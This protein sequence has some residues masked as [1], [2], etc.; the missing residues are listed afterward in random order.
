MPSTTTA[1]A[2]WRQRPAATLAGLGLLSGVISAIYG[3][4]LEVAWLRPVAQIFFLDVGPTPIGL[5]FAAAI[6]IGLWAC[7]AN[8]WTVPVALV[9]AMYAWSAA[10]QVAFR[11]QRNSGDDLHLIGASLGAGAVGAGLTHLGC[12]LLAP[13]LRRPVSIAATIVVGALA[14]LLFYLGERSFVDR[15]LLFLLWQPA[16]AFTIGMG[17]VARRA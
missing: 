11:L 9:A 8:P 14:G 5:F 16:V 1:I 6:A 4:D 12:A 10:I 17:L 3:Y 2:G 13:G 7:T 15:R